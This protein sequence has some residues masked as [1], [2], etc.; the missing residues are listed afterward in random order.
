MPRSSILPS[1]FSMA[2]PSH[3]IS[4]SGSQ[5]RRPSHLAISSLSFSE[6]RSAI[7]PSTSNPSDVLFAFYDTLTLTSISQIVSTPEADSNEHKLVS[8][9]LSGPYTSPTLPELIRTDSTFSKFLRLS[10]SRDSGNL[11]A[12]TGLFLHWLSR[13]SCAVPQDGV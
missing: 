5:A 3:S 1:I 4:L 6:R 9:H 10:N 7:D 12:S 2:T 13:I 11:R 8:N